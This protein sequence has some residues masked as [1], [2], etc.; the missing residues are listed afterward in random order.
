MVVENAAGATAQINPQ[1]GNPYAFAAVT[2]A[3]KKGL[4]IR[5][6]SDI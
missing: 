4:S 1:P 5:R 3:A 6:G 2:H